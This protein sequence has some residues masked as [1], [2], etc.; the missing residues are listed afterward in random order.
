MSIS[1]QRGGNP[2]SPHIDVALLIESAFAVFMHIVFVP[3]EP[4]WGRVLRGIRVE[5]EGL[6]L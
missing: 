5:D 1:G 2:R 6:P 4:I 3:I